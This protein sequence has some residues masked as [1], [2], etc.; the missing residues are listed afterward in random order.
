MA[1]CDKMPVHIVSAYFNEKPPN[2]DGTLAFHWN[3]TTMLS[4]EPDINE[5]KEIV[6]N[7]EVKCLHKLTGDRRPKQPKGPFNLATDYYLVPQFGSLA[8]R[9]EKVI[10]YALM[11]EGIRP[12]KKTGK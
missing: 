11:K 7:P 6:L 4:L 8:E 1:K 9:E 3:P 12:M 5:A 2:G 10:Q